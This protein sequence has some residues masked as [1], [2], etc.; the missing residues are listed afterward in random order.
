MAQLCGALL[1]MAACAP[2]QAT[3]DPAVPAS[4]VDSGG[5]E[6]SSAA[7]RT[8]VTD[9]NAECPYRPISAVDS[10]YLFVKVQADGTRAIFAG[11]R[12]GPDGGVVE[13][14]IV[15]VPSQWSVNQV[16]VSPDREHLLVTAVKPSCPANWPTP[17]GQ[18]CSWGRGTL[19]VVSHE[20]RPSGDV[21]AY[22]NLNSQ[23]GKNGA[24]VGWS[25]WLTNTRALFNA[26]FAPAG[27]PLQTSPQDVTSVAY[28]LVL[29]PNPGVI[30]WGQAAGVNSD[31]CFVGRIHSSG[32][33]RGDACVDGQT[34][35]FT[36]RCLD[37][38]AGP[39]KW[40]WFNTHRDDGSGGVCSSTAG[41][42]ELVPVFRV[43]AV[44]VG[45][46]CE[47]KAFDRNAPIREPDFS[48]LWRH[49]G[50]GREWGD[51]QSTVSADG[52]VVAFWSQRG[53]EFGSPTDPC[54]ALASRDGSIG[55][56]ASRV[57]YCE[58]DEQLRCKQT[59]TLADAPDPWNAQG[60][61]YFHRASTPAAVLLL[62]SEANSTFLHDRLRGTKVLVVERGGGGHPIAP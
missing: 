3:D 31:R 14:L 49:I 27:V 13:Q 57:R 4:A 39:E 22:T 20:A 30:R 6:L 35:V 8:G 2:G 48:G 7:C 51:G 32:P 24:V 25:T 29:G 18:S 46:D 1:A 28:E 47:P 21:W 50:S 58:L 23:L 60:H 61:A 41:A 34:V 62:V 37:E 45:V 59:R 44:K 43:Y 12:P 33:A 54:E 53:Y 11:R 10:E 40:A 42:A 9:E 19:W 16:S 5:D 15:N 52:K 26:K 56:G 36:R 38:P 55:N 17:E